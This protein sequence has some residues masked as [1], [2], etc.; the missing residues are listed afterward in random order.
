MGGGAREMVLD[1]DGR[2]RY[3]NSRGGIHKLTG[4][5]L[6]YPTTGG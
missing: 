5:A 4:F 3:R 1:R 6:A 2:F